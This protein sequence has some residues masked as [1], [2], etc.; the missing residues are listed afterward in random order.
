LPKSLPD[1]SPFKHVSLIAHADWSKDPSKRWLSI[2]T[3]Q[4]D[5]RWLLNRVQSADGIP[6]LFAYLHTLNVAHGSILAGFDFAIGLPYSY[7]SKARIRN[8]LAVLALFGHNEW[9]EFYSPAHNELDISI[10]RPFYPAVP[11]KAHR[12]H[13]EHGLGLDFTQ[14]YRLCE[15][16]HINRR[17]ACPLFWTLGSQQVGKAAISGWRDLLTPALSKYGSNLKIWPFSGSLTEL[18]QADNILVVESYPA[19]FYS[20]LGLSFSTPTRKSKRSHEDRKTFSNHLSSWAERHLLDLDPLII[21]MILDGFGD[22]SFGEDRFDALIGLYGMI[23]IVQGFHPSGEPFP[24]HVRRVEG[25]IIAK[26]FRER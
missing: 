6:D 4:S 25:W 10:F 13:L 2:A 16:S 1:T 18:C 26:E 3:L 24:L 20:H 17:A 12:S 19:E 9:R 15:V 23:N 7:A 11:G 14:L 8:F 22:D 5:C 21:R